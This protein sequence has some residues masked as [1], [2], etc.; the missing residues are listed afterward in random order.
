MKIRVLEGSI[1]KGNWNFNS[2]LNCISKG[3]TLN[4]VTLDLKKN[5]KSLTVLNQENY[6]SFTGTAGW[7]FVG[8]T[9]GGLLSGGVALAGFAGGLA[10]GGKKQNSLVAIEL[11][12]ESKFLAEV[13][14][15]V[16]EELQKYLYVSEKSNL[17]KK[18]SVS[19]FIE[20]SIKITISDLI[21]ESDFLKPCETY[22]GVFRIFYQG[23]QKFLVITNLRL[24][25]F[26]EAKSI[27][28][29]CFSISIAN[30]NKILIGKN[31]IRILYKG[32]TLNL[33]YGFETN[34][35]NIT[36]ALEILQNTTISKVSLIPKDQYMKKRDREMKIVVGTILAA[37]SGMFLWHQASTKILRVSTSTPNSKHS[38]QT[39]TVAPRKKNPDCLY[40]SESAIPIG[41]SH[42][43]YKRRVKQETGAKCLLFTGE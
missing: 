32:K 25:G 8:L 28:K 7:G 26:H 40:V 11:K 27:E 30:I 31:A 39:K 13:N 36:N 19:G 22:N 3:G 2:H 17:V 34:E 5:I 23:K 15:K 6:K 4:S 21:K 9:V 38:V 18:N 1:D 24:I 33:Y 42:K 37:I 35:E 10:A 29:M 20:E 43:E 16:L 41:M 12:D 14:K